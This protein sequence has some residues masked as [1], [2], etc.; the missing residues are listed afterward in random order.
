MYRYRLATL[1][2]RMLNKVTVVVMIYVHIDIN[3]VTY[4]P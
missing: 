4:C 1:N 3:V 2:N